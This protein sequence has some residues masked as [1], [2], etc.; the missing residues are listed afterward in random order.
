MNQG[1]SDI[2]RKGLNNLPYKMS[3]KGL[4][5]EFRGLFDFFCMDGRRGFLI[6]VRLCDE[7]SAHSCKNAQRMIHLINK[8][9]TYRVFYY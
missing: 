6:S 4:L 1:Q 3:K 7:L 5:E 9:L 8:T 2:D